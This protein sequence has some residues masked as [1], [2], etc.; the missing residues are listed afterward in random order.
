MSDLLAEAEREIR[1]KPREQIEE[2]TAFKWAARA[3]AAYRV[4]RSGHMRDQWL[5]DA[6]HYQDEACEHAALADHSG[7][8]LRAV[9]EWMRR[10]IPPGAL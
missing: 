10:Y 1:Q 5:R 6:E 3:V 2:E 8:V 7:E 4:F 9:R